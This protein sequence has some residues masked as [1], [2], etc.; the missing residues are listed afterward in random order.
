MYGA[1]LG[2]AELKGNCCHNQPVAP[3][4]RKTLPT[5]SRRTARPRQ[6]AA[7]QREGRS[8][9]DGEELARLR[10][11]QAVEASLHLGFLRMEHCTPPSPPE[12]IMRL[13]CA[14]RFC[15]RWRFDRV[16]TSSRSGFLRPGLVRCAL[17][18]NSNVG[19]TAWLRGWLTGRSRAAL[20]AEYVG[21]EQPYE[22][23]GSLPEYASSGSYRAALPCRNMA[24]PQRAARPTR[25]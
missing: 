15:R 1:Q 11:E 22:C 18:P 21:R 13:A 16:T 20:L 23:L 4:P 3:P 24:K 6:A 12:N 9:A 14:R 2:L 7:R 5:G 19:R 17:P 8:T 10:R 25:M